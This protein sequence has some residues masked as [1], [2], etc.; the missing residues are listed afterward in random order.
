LL[1]AT[2]RLAEAEPL[3][4]RALAIDE[5]SYGA[6]HPKVAIAPEQPGAVAPGHEPAGGGRAADAPRAGHRRAVLRA[7]H[8][9]VAIRLNNLAQLLQATNRLAEA[10]PLMRRALAIDE[11]SFGTN[12]PKVAI[13]L[14]NLAQLLQAT[15]RLAE[16]EPLM[17]RA[18][19]IDEQSFGTSTPVAIDLNNLAQ[20][21][22]ATNRLA[23]AEPLMRRALA[24]D[25]QSFGNEHPNVAIRPEQPGPVAPGHQP[26]GRGRAADAPGA[27]HRRAEL[28]DEHPNVAI[29]LNNLAQL[30][31][32]TNRLAE[33]EPLMRRAL[34]IDEQ[35]YGTEHPNVAI[36]SEQ[37]GPVASGHQPAGGGR[38]ADAP[39]AGHRRAELRAE[40]PNVAIRDLNNLASV[41]SG[42]QPAGRGRAADAPRAVIEQLL[43][44]PSKAQEI[45]GQLQQEDPQLFNELIAWIQSQQS[46]SAPKEPQQQIEALRKQATEKEQTLGSSHADT[47]SA[48]NYL[49][50]HLESM[51][52]FDEAEAEYRKAVDRAPGDIV[53]LGN[54]AFF[55][56]NFRNDFTA[57]RELYRRA[58]KAESSDSINQTNFAGLCLVMHETTEALQHLREAW[59]LIAGN[60]DR[61]TAR[62]LFLRAAL[63]ATQSEDHRFYL[64]QLKTVFDQGIQPMPSRNISVRQF[65]QRNLAAEEFALFDAIYTAINEPDGLNKLRALAAWQAIQPRPLDEPWPL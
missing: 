7:E 19:A 56:Q 9:N 16:A 61:Y 37:P 13:R 62:I 60:A 52:A 1:Q 23:E 4:R 8:P 58:L 57:A 20:L 55:L 5:Q 3:M 43:Q 45:V 25:E 65:L 11:Q 6:E 27:G 41:A 15:N 50:K 28:R 12:H 54:Y 48:I 2:N 59:R 38:A 18:L 39:G 24:I 14:N 10:E 30:L 32:A 64:G 36:R 49:A 42:H 35:S 26:A 22:Q 21:L 40:H 53:V 44:D 51:D 17:R 29:D 34:A 46:S 47:V 33:A 63:A 31:Q